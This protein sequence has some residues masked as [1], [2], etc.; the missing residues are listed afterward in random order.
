MKKMRGLCCHRNVYAGLCTSHGFAAWA[1]D[2]PEIY[3]PAAL[4]YAVLAWMG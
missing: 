2:K 4:L 1:S 3:V